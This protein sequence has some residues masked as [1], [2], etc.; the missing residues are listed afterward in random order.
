MEFFEHDVL[1]VDAVLT[2]S[3]VRVWWLVTFRG[4]QIYRLN[5]RPRIP[6]LWQGSAHYV[7]IPAGAHH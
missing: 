4:Y 1:P 5:R 6:G 3:R 2:T 7:L